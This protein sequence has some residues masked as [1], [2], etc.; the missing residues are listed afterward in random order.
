MF[1]SATVQ[2]CEVGVGDVKRVGGASA[3]HH[4]VPSSVGLN[5]L[6]I[7]KALNL[8]LQMAPGRLRALLAECQKS[9]VNVNVTF[10]KFHL[11]FME[12]FKSFCDTSAAHKGPHCVCAERL[13][14][15]YSCLSSEPYVITGA[16]INHSNMPK[17]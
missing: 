8:F 5:G 2:N 12:T 10:D 13:F 11:A 9:Q 14:H 6:L 4:R 7:K 1:K 15:F 16:K 17:D 3:L